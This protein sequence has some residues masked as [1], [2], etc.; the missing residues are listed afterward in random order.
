LDVL[1]QNPDGFVFGSS[2]HSWHRLTSLNACK[3]LH[4]ILMISLG[5]GEDFFGR[6]AFHPTSN[7]AATRPFLRM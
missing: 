1:Q 6:V 5:I 7:A 4:R 2:R 3:L